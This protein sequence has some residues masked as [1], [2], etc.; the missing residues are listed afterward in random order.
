[1]RWPDNLWVRQYRLAD[2]SDDVEQEVD[3]LVGAAL[4]AR[5]SV[6][7]RVGLLDTGFSMYSEELEWQRRIRETGSSKNEEQGTKNKEQ[8]ARF[9]YPRARA[10]H[11]TTN[12]QFGM[13]SSGSDPSKIVYLPEATIIHHE[14]KSS[15]QVIARRYIQFQ[16]SRLRYARMV[17]G[18]TFAALLYVFLL[19]IYSVE[20]VVEA[21]KWLL[22]HKQALR[23][24]RV[25]VYWQVLRQLHISS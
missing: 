14:G 11:G 22:R 6:I 18:E 8:M 10:G 1:V 3:W 19:A 24:E 5:W 23:R 20:L 7:E 17:Y 13:S 2:R 25:K 12:M 9:S 16:N 4:L 21:A 15:E